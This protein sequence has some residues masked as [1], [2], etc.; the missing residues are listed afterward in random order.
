MNKNWFPG[1][2]KPHPN[3]ELIK[4]WADGNVA[5]VQVTRLGCKPV[6]Q[7]YPGWHPSHQYEA[8]VKNESWVRSFMDDEGVT[9]TVVAHTANLTAAEKQTYVN[10]GTVTWLHDWVSHSPKKAAANVPR[11]VQ[12]DLLTASSGNLPPMRY[13]AARVSH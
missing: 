13:S 5:S 12:P 3:V 10:Y 9:H 6:M 7:A 4:D 11:A 1:C 2:G 8:A